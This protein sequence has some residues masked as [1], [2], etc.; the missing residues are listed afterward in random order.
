MHDIVRLPGHY[1]GG[2]IEGGVFLLGIPQRCP[3]SAWEESLAR[4]WK[5]CVAELRRV[6]LSGVV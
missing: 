1:S 5:F 6:G 3:H 2:G 4:T